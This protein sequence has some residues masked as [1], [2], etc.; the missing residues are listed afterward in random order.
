MAAAK[1]DVVRA[2]S[3]CQ[4]TGCEGGALKA[5]VV[6]DVLIGADGVVTILLVDRIGGPR[7]APVPARWVD[8]MQAV[9][10]AVPGVTAVRMEHRPYGS[11]APS[12]E[13][14]AASQRPAID[15]GAARVVAVVS[16]KGGVGKSTVTANLALAL[17]RLGRRVG[18]VD[19]DIYG[20]SMPTLLGAV[21]PPG[22]TA[23]KRWIPAQANGVGV[24]SMDFFAG[25]R[26][27][28]VIWRGPMLGKALRDFLTRPLW[29][30]LDIMLLDLPPGTGDMALDV[31]EMLPGCQ[32]VVVT[33]PDPMAARVAIRAGKMAHRTGHTVLG[34]VENMAWLRCAHGSI[35]RP[36]GEGGGDLVGSG[37]GVPVLCRVP[38]GGATLPGTGLFA[39]D[40]EPGRAFADLAEAVSRPVAGPVAVG[41]AAG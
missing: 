7:G 37:L 3:R 9:V 39:P 2:L 11:A 13:A 30:E 32:E 41:L 18:V 22:V 21:E 15:V 6:I 16:G 24:L 20:F 29:G 33:T 23:D 5:G 1:R 19:A 4:L 38:L 36:F 10:A 26:G 31:H 28:A 17:V 25:P 14:Y 40:S 34:V 35:L 8:A 27:D 12:A